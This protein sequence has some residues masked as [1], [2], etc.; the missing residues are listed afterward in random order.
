MIDLIKEFEQIQAKEKLIEVTLIGFKE[1]Y[2][3]K[4]ST[5]DENHVFVAHQEIINYR[6]KTITSATDAISELKNK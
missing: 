4:N 1:K 5:F 3:V 2:N 6:N